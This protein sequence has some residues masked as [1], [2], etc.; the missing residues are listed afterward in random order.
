VSQSRIPLSKDEHLL[1]QTSPHWIIL[2]PSALLALWS[3]ASMAMTKRGELSFGP[4][5]FILA[6]LW[7]LGS[8]IDYRTSIYIVTSHRVYARWRHGLFW[9]RS[10]HLDLRIRQIESSRTG[11]TLLG[12]ILGLFR[13]GYGTVVVHGT[14]TGA[15]GIRKVFKPMEFKRAMD[16][17][18]RQS[19]DGVRQASLTGKATAEEL[20][21]AQG[22]A[23]CPQCGRLVPQGAAFC[24]SCGT[25]ATRACRQCGTSIHAAFCPAC[26]T[27]NA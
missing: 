21:R 7:G 16:E 12:F 9:L 2:L 6:C 3:I 24:G 1:F 20:V 26:G 15:V 25:A 23:N 5:E 17:A 14:G 8:L 10:G 4:F 18:M 19:D 22:G 13:R 11:T 27:P